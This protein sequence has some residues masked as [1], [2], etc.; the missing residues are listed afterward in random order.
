M[1]FGMFHENEG[2]G[3][4]QPLWDATATPPNIA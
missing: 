2:L 3:G 4:G 1:E